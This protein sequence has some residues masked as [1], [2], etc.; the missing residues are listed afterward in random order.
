MFIFQGWIECVGIAD[1]S[2]YDLTQHAIASGQKLV[3]EKKLAEPRMVEQ[4]VCLPNKKTLGSTYKAD[5][6]ML[7]AHLTQLGEEECTKLAQQLKN[8]YVFGII[9]THLCVC[10]L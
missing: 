8:G 10:V 9:N 4:T 3:A 1:R 5:G 6:K 7:I 2:C